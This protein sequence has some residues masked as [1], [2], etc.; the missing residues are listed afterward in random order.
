MP[1]CDCKIAKFI[2]GNSYGRSYKASQE[3]AKGDS[4]SA[5]VVA[6]ALIWRAIRD[7]AAAITSPLTSLITGVV[8]IDIIAYLNKDY[9]RELF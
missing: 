1:C 2:A 7:M 3:K 4:S 9:L 6:V 8:L 5:R